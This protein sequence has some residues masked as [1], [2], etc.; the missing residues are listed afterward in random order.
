MP[1]LRETVS[2]SIGASVD[3]VLISSGSQSVLDGLGRLLVRNGSRVGILSPSYMGI[4]RT[5]AP[6]GANF[7]PIASREGRIDL[8]HLQK[9]MSE[10]LELLYLIPHYDNP[11]GSTLSMAERVAITTLADQY[12]C[13]IVEDDA[14]R[15][16]GFSSPP[17]TS[18]YELAPHTVVHLRTFAKTVAPGL[19]LGWAA[20]PRNVL[21]GLAQIRLASDFHPS[22]LPQMVVHY[23]LRSQAFN[24][25]IQAIQEIYAHRCDV[26]S[27]ALDDYLGSEAV[28]RKP[29]GGFFYFLYLRNISNT[30][31]LL[32][33]AMRAG[34]SFMPGSMFVPNRVPQSSLRLSFSSGTDE[35]LC[36]GIKLL[37]DT[38]ASRS[39]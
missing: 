37:R 34:V 21:E 7:V 30:D 22:T 32:E 29:S 15:E 24:D 38:I 19:R 20:A 33:H 18:L 9:V 36:R 13:L 5:W 16:L 4:F 6:I 12:G 28:W 35:E 26:M 3:D 25:H 31:Q 11:S 27:A 39:E 23:A 8:D 1:R 10:G 17:L 2:Q 14:Y